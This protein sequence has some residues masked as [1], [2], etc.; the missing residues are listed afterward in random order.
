MKLPLSW[1][2]EWIGLEATP[3]QIAL[4][5]THAGL[6]V[7]AY[8]SAKIAFDGVIAAE[9]IHT[10]K[11]PNA[12]K[13]C[14]AKVFDGKE[15]HQVVCGAPN[16]RPGLKTAF[17]RIGAILKT[18]GQPDFQIKKTTIRGVESC[19]MLCS[20]K[21][22]AIGAESSGII[23]FAEQVSIGADLATLYAD[24]IFEISLTPNLGHCASV[25]GIAR[26][27]HAAT[28]APIQR[29]KW[30]VKESAPAAE[31][32]ISIEIQ[33]VKRCPKYACRLIKNVK[34]GP[35][36]QWLQK[37]LEAC[38]LR[39]INNIVDITNYVLMELGHPLH[40]FDYHALEG[41]K[42]VVRTALEGD[43]FTGLDGKDYRLENEDLLI[44]DQNKPVALAGVLGGQNSEVKDATTQI[45]LEAAYFDPKTIRKT[46]KRLGLLTEAARRFEKGADPQN[47]ERALDRAAQLV[48]EIAGGEVY[49][50]IVCEGEGVPSKNP[51]ACRLNRINQLLG[52]QLGLSEVENILHRLEMRTEWDGHDKIMV[53]PPSYRADIS[54]EID[55]VEE[56]ARVYGY[57]N[58]AKHP[59][60]YTSSSLPHNP[61]Y[62]FETRV[63]QHLLSLGLQEFVNCDLI[64]PT[65]LNIIQSEP[66]PE[67]AT[68]RVLNPTSI[69]QSVL[70]TSLLPG[71]LQVVKHNYD[72]QVHD[73]CGFEV[74]RVHFRRETG[75]KEESMAAI[76]LTG[77]ERPLHWE[78]KP[79]DYDFYDI[80]GM[81][82]G[83][84]QEMGVGPCR[85][86]QRNIPIFHPGRQAAIYAG[87]LKI[88]SFGE[89]HPAILRRLDVPQKIYF[90]ELDLH[91]LF[92][93]PKREPKFY[94]LAAFPCSTRDLTLTLE[95]ATPIQAI[96]EQVNAMRTPLLESAFLVDVYTSD[97]LGEGKKNV[98]IRFI[99]RDRKKTVAQE[100]VDAEHTKIAAE[101]HAAFRREQNA[102]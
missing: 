60:L 51:I 92:G 11:H 47:I 84:L 65:L 74:G 55:L 58:I 14:V 25:L 36:P 76:V 88:G 61:M 91:Q 98:T 29:P 85:Y 10:E 101:I 83:L 75:Y 4:W 87:E 13:L 70:R 62:L 39:P 2:K 45:L 72:H 5:L 57:D 81:L 6:E 78:A 68:V 22:L 73:L 95:N 38:D 54:Q 21:E 12:D 71:L 7:D 99:Y 82:E 86:E 63:K 3:H 18:E 79:R 41:H 53:T 44:C 100:T 66:M 96:F 64:G 9:V 20:E 30:T 34:V 67:N 102:H 46:S 49:Q 97:K 27:L 28:S 59:P 16:C 37:R 77:K 24:T 33:D 31:K 19:G 1:I 26:E 17:A 48:Q 32:S 40:A 90:A 43:A 50:G 56:V 42:I 15:T 94:S 52:T 89:I 80:K 35:S 23:E 8:Y 69:E 93:L